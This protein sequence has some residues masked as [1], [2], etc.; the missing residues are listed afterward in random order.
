VNSG[1]KHG[2]HERLAGLAV[3]AA[4]GNATLARQLAQR[5]NRSTTAGREV[6]VRRAEGERGVGVEQRSR[7]RA[8]GVER[9]LERGERLP[10]VA[11]LAVGLGAGDVHH[12]DA[13]ELVLRLKSAMSDEI[14]AICSRGGR[15]ERRAAR[16]SRSAKPTSASSSEP[17]GCASRNHARIRWRR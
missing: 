13:V 11:V 17:G 8:T 10:F 5:R 1:A 9:A 16:G 4:V 14:A 15:A 6:H 12:D 2:L 3:V 7:L